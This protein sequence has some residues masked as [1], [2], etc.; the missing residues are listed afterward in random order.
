MFHKLRNCLAISDITCDLYIVSSFQQLANIFA[1]L[2]ETASIYKIQKIAKGMQRNIGNVEN[3]F[4]F[5]LHLITTEHQIECWQIN[6]FFSSSER[7]SFWNC[8]LQQCCKH[9]LNTFP[10]ASRNHSLSVKL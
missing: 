2:F 5:L 3:I 1:I 7:K 8:V 4:I 10:K 6:R 9:Y